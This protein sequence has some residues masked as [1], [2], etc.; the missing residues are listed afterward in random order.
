LYG[1]TAPQTVM[2]ATAIPRGRPQP[3]LRFSGS[4]R[5][6]ALLTRALPT[7]WRSKA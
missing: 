4:R 6:L 5:S 3:S 2:S 7:S 1:W